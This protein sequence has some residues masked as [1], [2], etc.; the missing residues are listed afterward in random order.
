MEKHHPVVVIPFAG[1]WSDV[2]SWNAVANITEA[3]ADG[4]RV[5]GQGVLMASKRTF[6]H[7][8]HRTVAALGVNDLLIVDT[9]D[10]LLVAHTSQSENVK[11]LVAYLN[12]ENATY[13]V[14]HRK[15]HRPWG[16]YDTVDA[17]ARFQVKRIGV[18]PGASLSLQKHAFRAEHWI[19]VAGTAQVTRGS[20]T[21]TL[22]ENQSTY[23][24]IGEV[25]RLA[26]PGHEFLEMIEVQSGT[27]LGEDDIIR[28]EDVYGRQAAV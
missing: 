12:S 26:N 22:S 24:P 28:L 15:V 17:G 6:I 14:T 5:V 23:I 3:D 20:E 8:P 21:F 11:N 9:P 25:H 19:V 7:A 18:K 13:T 16:W 1:Q 10:A 27:Y 4:N 2:G